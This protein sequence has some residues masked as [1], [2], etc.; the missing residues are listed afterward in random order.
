MSTNMKAVE[1][2][3]MLLSAQSKDE[4]TSVLSVVLPLLL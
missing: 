4:D 2:S 1:S 3:S